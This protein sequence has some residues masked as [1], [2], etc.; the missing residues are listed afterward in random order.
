MQH[1]VARA[2]VVPEHCKAKRR[3]GQCVHAGADRWGHESLTEGVVD[4][5]AIALGPA[6]VRLAG[7]GRPPVAP[8][9][10]EVP[11]RAAARRQEHQDHGQSRRCS[12][13]PCHNRHHAG[14]RNF[15]IP[16]VHQGLIA[17]PSVDNKELVVWCYMLC[18][19]SVNWRSAY[20][21]YTRGSGVMLP[22]YC[23]LG[24]ERR[25]HN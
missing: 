15:L 5:E 25:D 13:R 7:V 24:R 9:D 19:C 22:L 10:V 11:R 14:T 21:V 4:L 8:A 20:C 17:Q 12:Q 23:S 3:C 18:A 6:V 16:R 1:A 2:L